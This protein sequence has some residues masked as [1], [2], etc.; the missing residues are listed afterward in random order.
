MIGASQLPQTQPIAHA[1]LLLA[2]VAASGLAIGSLKYRGIGLG[3]AGVLFAGILFG[4]FGQSVD[5][6]I[7]DFVK[8]FG[9]IL[10]VFTIGLQLGPGFIAALRQQGLQLNLLALA[11]VA[12]GAIV[13]ILGVKML[14][15]DAAAGLGL[16]SGATTNTPS[17]G[18]A[19]QTLAILPGISADRAAL[20]ALAYAVAYPAGIAGIIG[21]LLALRSIFR[22][23]AAREAQRYRAEQQRGFEPLQRQALI[24]ENRSLEGLRISDV[25]GQRE[26]GVTISRL[27]KAGATAVQ[28]A[29]D[30]T[31]LHAGDVVLAVGLRSGLE[32]FGKIIG[33]EID[34]DLTKSPG[35]VTWRRI[36]VTRK[37]VLGK[38]IV[39]LAFDQS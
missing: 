24:V 16:F 38:S 32:K 19:Q 14:H 8:E 7:L 25:P 15:V 13:V 6:R 21:S 20:P 29:T 4:H 9:L 1:M 26:T 34:V 23:D 10:F 30:A 33:R 17:L 3:S 36:V 39:E 18:A 12:A 11:I 28:T 22:I 31:Q 5:H 2:A 27:R 37:G 35:D